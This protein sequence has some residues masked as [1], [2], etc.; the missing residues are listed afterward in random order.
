[1]DAIIII[2]FCIVS[3]LSLGLIS[4]LT[5]TMALSIDLTAGPYIGAIYGAILGVLLSPFF[6]IKRTSENIYAVLVLCF[7]LS[8]PVALVAGFTKLLWLAVGLTVLSMFS[9]YF[10]SIK[11]G[12]INR[13]DA[14]IPIRT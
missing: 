3:G 13:R 6:A 12:V 7:T 2:S 1:M 4:G 11:A 14:P 9:V 10:F 5:M 8:A